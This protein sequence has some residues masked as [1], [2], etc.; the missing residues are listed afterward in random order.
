MADT[1]KDESLPSVTNGDRVVTKSV[2]YYI[3]TH[4]DSVYA[5]NGTFEKLLVNYAKTDNLKAA[6]ASI[7]SLSAKQGDFESAT[8]ESLSAHDAK[9]ESMATSEA[10]MHKATIDS[11]NV[12]SEK[13]GVLDGD[14]ARIKYVMA[15][16]T[17]SDTVDA[18]HI[19]AKNAV[20]EN[21]VVKDA[22]ID[23][24]S[25]DK[26][27]A[28]DIDTN[29]VTIH[30]GDSGQSTWKGNTIKF[31]DGN[32]KIRVQLG[33]D[34]NG[35]YNVY[36][37]DKNGNTM[38]DPLG[39]TKDGINRQVIDN[40]AVMDNALIAGSKLD[41]DDVIKEVNGAKKT[42]KS[43]RIYFDDQKQTLNVVLNSITESTSSAV[44][45][46]NAANSTANQANSIANM[47][48]A[49]AENTSNSAVKN[50]TVE[51]AVNTSNSTAPTTGW[52]SSTP[53]WSEG[54]YIWSR[55]VATRG[56]GTNVYSNPTCVTGH[57]GATGAQG[58]KGDTGAQG[59]RGLQGEKGEQGIQGD[60][61]LGVKAVVP[62]YYLSTSSASQSG[63]SWTETQPAWTSGKYIWTR[64]QV[65]WDDN[66][67]TYSTP[68]LA[69]AINTANDKASQAYNLANSA[70]GTASTALNKANSAVD[71]ANAGMNKWLVT[72]YNSG[73][74][75][76]SITTIPLLLI[77][78]LVP[79]STMEY[80]NA[81][82]DAFNSIPGP[83]SGIIFSEELRVAYA[84]TYV[85]F[86]ADTTVSNLVLAT[87]DGGTLYL[88][89]SQIIRNGSYTISS[90]VS[91]TF[92]KGWNIIE[93]VIHNGSLTGGFALA[94]Y[95]SSAKTYSALDLT[96]LPNF[97]RMDCYCSAFSG[98]TAYGL[99]VN[100]KVLETSSSLETVSRTVT[101]NSNGVKDLMTRTSQVETNVTDLKNL[102]NT[103]YSTLT[104][105]YNNQQKTIDGTV[106]RLG[107]AEN[108]IT[109]VANDLSNLS[110]GGRNLLL[111]TKTFSNR[112]GDYGY[113]YII[114]AQ[115]STQGVRGNCA[116]VTNG[117]NDGSNWYN[118]LGYSKVFNK[119]KPFIPNT[120]YTLSFYVKADKETTFT[121]YF[122]PTALL[123]DGLT[124]NKATTEWKKI[125][126]TWKTRADSDYVNDNEN[127]IVCR[128]ETNTAPNT[129]IW[130][131]SPK[132]EIGNKATDWSPAPE[133]FENKISE[134]SN[135]FATYKQTMTEN[136]SAI[137]RTYQ[138]KDDMA[139]YATN[140]SVQSAISQSK[141]DIT[142]SV[143][144]NYV[145]TQNYD[146]DK[147][148]IEK[149]MSSA[150]QKITDNAIVSAVKKSND[151]SDLQ[152]NASKLDWKIM[153]SSVDL[154]TMK[155]DGRYLLKGG[156]TNAYDG[157]NGWQYL[158]VESVPDNNRVTQTMWHD[159]GTDSGY[160]RKLG[161][162]GSW[163][164]WVREANTANA[165]SVI[166]QSSESIKIQ[167]NRIDIDGLVTFNSGN[168]AIANKIAQADQKAEDNKYYRVI[169]AAGD[170]NDYPGTGLWFKINGKSG[171]MNNVSRGLNVISIN[172][173]SLVIEGTWGFD[174][175]AGGDART[176]FRN[177]ISELNSGDHIIVVLSYDASYPSLVADALRSIGG[178]VY[179]SSKD[180]YR[181]SYA[182][183]GRSNLGFG[184]GVERYNPNPARKGWQAIVSCRVSEN[185]ALMSSN[186]GSLGEY[187]QDAQTRIGAIEQWKTNSQVDSK[188]SH[189]YNVVNYWAQNASSDTTTI[190]GGL[191]QTN[192]ITADKI[193]IGD[194]T[195][196]CQLSPNKLYG[197]TYS[198]TED[199]NGSTYTGYTFNH[200]GRDTH[201]SNRFP[202][203][204]GDMFRVTYK[205]KCN[206][207]A[208]DKNGNNAANVFPQ[209][210]IFTYKA[211]G[212]NSGWYKP[213]HHSVACGT[214][215]STE[216]SEIITLTGDSDCYFDVCIQIEAWKDFSGW[217][218][219]IDPV[220]QRMT[221]GELIVDGAI[222]A[223]KISANA[224]TADKISANAITADKISANAI[225]ADNISANAITADK[226]SA[227]AITADKISANA[228]TAD[229]ITTNDI[230]GT[231][232]RINLRT[233][234]FDYGNGKLKWDGS[235]LTING[236]GTFSGNI[237]AREGQIASY[238]ISGDYLMSTDQQ[239]GMS[240][241]NTSFWAGYNKSDGSYKFKV[242][243]DG[244]FTATN[245]NISGTI[246]A[247]GGRIADYTI[248][249]AKLVGNNVGLSG[250]AGQGWAFWAGSN[251]ADSAPFRVG[252]EGYLV[253][254]NA[255]ISGTISGTTIN[256]GTING[257]TITGTVTN[258]GTITGGNIW[259]DFVQAQFLQ[260][261]SNSAT[262]GHGCDIWTEVI[263]CTD[264]IGQTGASKIH[265]TGNGVTL[266][267]GHNSYLSVSS[268][269]KVWVNEYDGKG[270]NGGTIVFSRFGSHTVSFYWGNNTGGWHLQTYVD[271]T[272]VGNAV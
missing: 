100:A 4:L 61:G 212:S 102:E 58:P 178:T 259:G 209:I 265:L 73:K 60:K 116:V 260:T 25:A 34:S 130:I 1:T 252:H 168:N 225:T 66:S 119:D 244:A 14:V 175:Y 207:T 226:I 201:I 148:A 192:T 255:T 47:A 195:N 59:L 110:I 181:E 17:V 234:T 65:T 180:S 89:G 158:I 241:G 63:G 103:H 173:I 156:V 224:I 27:T 67:V 200:F 236:N 161:S 31:I 250:T 2:L 262:N 258:G 155:T 80:S 35:D 39:L 264:I 18:I 154:N 9:F 69:N 249:G 221:T 172:P 129:K 76:N 145:K 197:S 49:T 216:V 163:T 123:N 231:N 74:S 238:T 38:F 128:I 170:S 136:L 147:E 196:Y 77:N 229:K 92:K 179:S 219:I 132:L 64:S 152:K 115:I 62:Q 84:V 5:K 266:Y 189:A 52:A 185:G 127:I 245:A 254:S 51:Y 41:I 81:F 144:T 268:D 126:I 187:A 107:N 184:N 228:I 114:R 261:A 33:K 121:S 112:T 146:K 177:K 101:D 98:Q 204:K 7:D 113:P 16:N 30:A 198:T 206:I 223:D 251:D 29:K 79:E 117:D 23:S 68:I 143:S 22:M 88:N 91:V 75:D 213:R 208:K 183:I 122:Y 96:K 237:T 15:G 135:D 220:V 93:A 134:Q 190:N 205:L 106:T 32:G 43:S 26:I 193:A 37:Y 263:K 56:D 95:D 72:K 165:I 232:G 133:D 138:R 167:A 124:I 19:T 12:T 46:A 87:D 86:N 176:N 188:L 36:I 44:T 153:D 142:S 186:S 150:E 118:V 55:T 57:K 71:Q 149:R 246:N 99:A 171:S 3:L 218:T 97:Q 108:R 48:K 269:D 256:G 83:R 248:N 8:V 203:K 166:N 82:S 243:K 11:L 272:Y 242:T 239:V 191:I 104:T 160:T 94:T 141:Q 24:V 120:N 159:N 40:D 85:N 267:G 182:L 199:F 227:N 164:P 194:F 125:V 162:G 137:G 169:E 230:V 109:T 151:W 210:S 10:S 90:E 271:D 157:C 70:N 214:N 215:Y 45:T 233:G 13:V 253:A 270:M 211:D 54:S 235:S 50:I 174:T 217:F 140:D 111:D 222:T 42:I 240:A 257:A 21:N 139:G 131:S 105:Q 53:K 6:E 247:S 20:F 202:C 28:L 78:K